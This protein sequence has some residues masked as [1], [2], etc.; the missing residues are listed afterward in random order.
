M[1]L[2]EMLERQEKNAEMV[3]NEQSNDHDQ[4]RWNGT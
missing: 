1:E 3:V 2:K 4:I